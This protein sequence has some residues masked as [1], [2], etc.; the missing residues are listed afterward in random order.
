M[1]L[2]NFLI[3]GAAKAGTT[4]L[5][6][7]LRQHPDIYLPERIKEPMFFCGIS[8]ERYNGPGRIYA[9]GKIATPEEYAGLFQEAN[10][11]R[12]V[13]EASVPYLFYHQ[14]TIRGIRAHLTTP[15]RI[16]ISLRHPAQRAYSNYLHHVRDGVEDLGFEDA[17]A[18]EAQRRD[19]GWWWGYQ[20]RAGGRYTAQVAAYLEAFGEERVHIVL[21]DDLKARPLETVRGI[22]AFL[23]VDAGFAPDMSERHNVSLVPRRPGI[24]RLL[25]GEGGVK[26]LLK[27]LIP[28]PLRRSLKRKVSEANMQRPPRMDE[29]IRRALTDEYRDEIAGL[30]G[31]I[32]RDLSHW[33]N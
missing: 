22:F 20:Y 6:H 1:T 15:P 16:V 13:G 5:Y 19:A 17:L 32:G 11:H 29:H 25:Q 24:Q 14:D 26:S 31:L 28:A 7:Y 4:A 8:E 23:G 33:L 21:Y 18:A 12:A 10:G 27:P 3:V 9:R 30:Q 2:P